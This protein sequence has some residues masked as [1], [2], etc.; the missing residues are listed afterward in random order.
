MNSIKNNNDN[1][2]KVKDLENIIQLVRK[3]YLIHPN[4]SKMVIA[5][6]EFV[7]LL[8]PHRNKD[9]IEFIELLSISIGNKKKIEKI[10]MTDDLKNVSYEYF[11]KSIEN[12]SKEEL[13]YLANRFFKISASRMKKLGKKD[14]LELVNDS[15]VNRDTLDAIGRRASES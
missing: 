6:D 4:N 11:V 15:I 13:I 9:A 12:F 8:H 5:L 7:K 14:V 3:L 10:K 1:V 2:V